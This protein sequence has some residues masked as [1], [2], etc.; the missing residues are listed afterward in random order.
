M[1]QQVLANVHVGAPNLPVGHGYAVR[2]LTQVSS[3]NWSGYADVSK[4]YTKVGGSWTQP[5][6][7]CHSNSDTEIAVFWVGIDGFSSGT[8]EQDG[9]LAICQSGAISYADWWEMY[10]TN[11]V[12]EVNAISAGSKFTSTVTSTGSTY[13]L[14]VT[15]HTNPSASFTQTATCS[16]CV[17]S[18]AEWIAE[19]PSGSGGLFVLPNF[20]KWSVTKATVTS[21]TNGVISSFPDDA[22]T[23][24]NNSGQTLVSV[25]ALNTGGNGFTATWHRSA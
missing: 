18:S 8:V 6:I 3:G 2:G 12:I 21:G 20:H 10:P 14:T 24:K 15:D 25:G 9:T 13:K 4:T 22:I 16:S 1:L 19:R 17:K 7:T 11:N 23:M 5:A